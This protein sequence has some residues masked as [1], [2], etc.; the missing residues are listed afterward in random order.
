M[1][2]IV[3]RNMPPTITDLFPY[4]QYVYGLRKTTLQLE[5]PKPTTNFKKRSIAYR[6]SKLWNSL[7]TDVKQS[8]SFA[9]FKVAIDK[10]YMN[11]KKQLESKS[12]ESM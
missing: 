12:K 3:N 10:S 6:S 1:Y 4:R 8:I 5:V 11:L 2:K 7:P 9:A